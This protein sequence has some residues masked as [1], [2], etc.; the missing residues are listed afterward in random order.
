MAKSKGDSMKMNKA[1]LFITVLCVAALIATGCGQIEA[2]KTNFYKGGE[3]IREEIHVKANVLGST[4]IEDFYLSRDPNSLVLTTASF[5]NDPNGVA[6][7][8]KAI[9]GA[10]GEGIRASLLPVP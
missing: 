8:V 1:E 10:V 5:Y 4:D 2:K 6:D 3:L 7:T 9:G